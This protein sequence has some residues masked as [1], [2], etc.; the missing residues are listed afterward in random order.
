MSSEHFYSSQPF[1]NSQHPLEQGLIACCIDQLI[2]LVSRRL[3]SGFRTLALGY[4]ELSV[5]SHAFRPRPRLTNRRLFLA[6]AG[7]KRRGTR[8]AKL[9]TAA[10]MKRNTRQRRAVQ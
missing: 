2:S 4:A 9:M 7:G 10:H 8:G 6:V 5:Q 3:G 1:R